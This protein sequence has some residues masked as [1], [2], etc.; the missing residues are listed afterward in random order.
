[1]SSLPVS[2]FHAVL[3]CS[4]GSV[5]YFTEATLGP[6]SG[7]TQHFNLWN[8]TNTHYMPSQPLPSEFTCEHHQANA[9]CPCECSSGVQ[10][11][12]SVWNARDI[13]GTWKVSRRCGSERAGP[14]AASAWRP[15]H[16]SDT[17]AGARP[18][19]F[20]G[21][22]A[23]QWWSLSCSHTPSTS[24]HAF[25]WNCPDEVAGKGPEKPLPSLRASNWCILSKRE[26]WY[27][28]AQ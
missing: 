3:F 24:A 20:C 23:C 12:S 17:C 14:S 13:G 4:R 27:Q 16:S 18:C 2:L 22:S 25:S 8:G 26:L 15:C 21:A 6:A 11:L 7:P 28:R 1:M 9:S 19:V 5:A 10:G